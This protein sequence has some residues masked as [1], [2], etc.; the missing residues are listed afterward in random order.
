MSAE[1]EIADG[2][3]F[4][5]GRN[6][7]RFLELLDER[8]IAEA[9]AS[10]CAMLGV[11][12]LHDRRFLDIGCGSGLFSLAARRLGAEVRSFDFDRQSVACAAELRRRYLPDDAG[13]R[14][15]PG[16]VLDPEFM[17][18]LGTYDVVYSWGVL[19]HTGA[20][21]IALERALARVA[22]N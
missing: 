14:I 6:W 9:E 10:L 13:W 19:H 16:S 22:A 18:A 21:W 2:Q 12:D 11:T 20:M 15:E 5:F 17:G 3:R 4:A 1:L 8:R 7:S